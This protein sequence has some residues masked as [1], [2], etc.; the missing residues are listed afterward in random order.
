M[1]DNV[2][3]QVALPTVWKLFAWA[4]PIICF[5][6]FCVAIPLFQHVPMTWIYGGLVGGALLACLCAVWVMDSARRQKEGSKERSDI[7]R[8]YL[9]GVLFSRLSWVE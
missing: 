9:F 7:A 6:L 3:T 5:G 8:Y 2:P 4:V 1:N